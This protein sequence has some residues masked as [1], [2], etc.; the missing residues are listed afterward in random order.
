MIREWKCQ[1]IDSS[2]RITYAYGQNVAPRIKCVR[3]FFYFFNGVHHKKSDGT[4]TGCAFVLPALQQVLRQ[5][6]HP[7]ITQAE[8]G[9]LDCRSFMLAQVKVSAHSCVTDDHC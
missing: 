8:I 9:T 2:C 6:Q 7:N 5:K 3:V 1:Y 4:K